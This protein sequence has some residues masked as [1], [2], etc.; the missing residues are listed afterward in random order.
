MKDLVILVADKSMKFTLRGGPGRH[1]ALGI[2]P[3]SSTS[4]NILRA[5]GARTTGPQMLALEFI[6][7]RHALLVLDYEGSGAAASAMELEQ[8]LDRDLAASWDDRG[9]AIVI[10]PEL[11]GWAWGADNALA[12]VLRWPR[13]ESIR[14]WLVAEGFA[15]NVDGKPQRPKE[16]LEAVFRICRRPRSASNYQEIARRVSL[17]HC[18]DSAFHRLRDVLRSWFPAQ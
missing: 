12:Q 4:D 3:V 17:A 13:S 8:K 1:H 18:T 2:R 9:K 15:V 6:R 7:F 16:A 14:E 10:D 5:C 11:D